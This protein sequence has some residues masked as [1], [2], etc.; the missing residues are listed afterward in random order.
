MTKQVE[1]PHRGLCS[2]RSLIFKTGK[3]RIQG[4]LDQKPVT[5]SIKLRGPDRLQFY[6][7]LTITYKNR[8]NVYYTKFL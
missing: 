4:S 8:Y 2:A 6:H 3:P 5:S 1:Y 7:T